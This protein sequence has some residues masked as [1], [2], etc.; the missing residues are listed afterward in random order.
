MGVT[1]WYFS[2]SYYMFS[3]V[4]HLLIWTEVLT[5]KKEKERSCLSAKRLMHVMQ[6]WL[7]Y[8]S[9]WIFLSN[10]LHS[11]HTF[12]LSFNDDEV[13]FY[14]T[15]DHMNQSESSEM[16]FFFDYSMLSSMNNMIRENFSICMCVCAYLTIDDN[17][18]LPIILM[19]THS[20]GWSV[21]H[22]LTLMCTRVHKWVFS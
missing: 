16:H 2:A 10:K 8:K 22:S 15:G 1:F 3:S 21:Y 11:L 13:L 14:W 17:L 9:K 5:V 6:S 4:E 20:S 19:W 7:R 12:H 18:C